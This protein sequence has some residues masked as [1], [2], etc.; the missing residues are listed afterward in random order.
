MLATF[1]G[2]ILAMRALG[3][4][5]WCECGGWALWKS[6]V[7]SSH[8]SQHL[9]DPYTITHFSHGLLFWC[10]FAVVFDRWAPRI[11]ARP[12]GVARRFTVP[13]RLVT[14]RVAAAVWEVV[15][16]SPWVIERYRTVTMSLDYLGDSVVNAIGDVLACVAGFF[17]AR[18]LG[19]TRTL[20]LFV[21]L[22][23]ALLLAIR[24]NL[25]LNVLMLTWP[26][27][28]VRSW[29]TAGHV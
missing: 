21:V 11:G 29:Q 19:V 16:N 18:W 28:A 13:W 23:L 17:T 12:A 3:R 5:W 15:E 7:W 27:E 10:L 4:I 24:D 25:S 9:A 8:C 20:I 6:D 2:M 1:V 22:E 26:I 14:A